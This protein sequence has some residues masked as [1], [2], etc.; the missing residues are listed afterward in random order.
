MTKDMKNN[1]W[2]IAGLH[3]QCTG[4]GRC[5]QGPDEGYIWATKKEL[6]MI[7]DH[8]DITLD[9][10]KDNYTQ[11]IGFR[12]TLIEEQKYNDCI[13]L[14]DRKKCA[15]YPCR[16]NQC[17]TWPFWNSNLQSPYSWNQSAQKCPGIN[18]GKLYTFEEIEKIR[19]QKQWW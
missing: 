18:K 17:R 10:L 1:K 19:N 6:Q 7:A 4:C 16:P 2:Y 13:F 14:R 5:C 12:R 11:L 15:I 3:F 8:L 9:K